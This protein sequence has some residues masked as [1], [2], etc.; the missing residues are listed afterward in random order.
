MALEIHKLQ[1][2]LGGYQFFGDLLDKIRQFY[3]FADAGSERYIPAQ[4]IR[5]EFIR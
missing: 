2:N 5:V 3:R 1:S 4:Q